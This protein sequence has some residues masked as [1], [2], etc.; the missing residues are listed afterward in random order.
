MTE[1]EEDMTSGAMEPLWFYSFELAGWF[2][3]SYNLTMPADALEVSAEHRA[4]LCA[5]TEEGQVIVPGSDGEPVLAD[6]PPPSNEV[7]AERER[8][9]RDQQLLQTDS[10][11]TR[12]RDELEFESSTTLTAEQ[13]RE[14][15]LFRSALR[16][17]PESSTFP[18]LPGRPT[19]PG[20]LIAFTK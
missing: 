4:K 17:W 11:V 1:H 3:P 2:S 8:R 12:H 16:K 13:Y 20:W 18:D 6:P 7:L 9:W 14:L 10:I 15:Q 5:G 19:P